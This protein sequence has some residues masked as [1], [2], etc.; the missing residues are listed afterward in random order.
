M[1]LVILGVEVCRIDVVIEEYFKQ[2]PNCF[3]AFRSRHIPIVRGSE[4]G[5]Y[6]TIRRFGSHGNVVT[7]F[8]PRHSEL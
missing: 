4:C 2:M 1:F 8:T 3:P 6:R 5:V 7:G